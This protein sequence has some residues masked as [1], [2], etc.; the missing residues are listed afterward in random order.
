MTGGARVTAAN[1]LALEQ[2]P[3]FRGPMMSMNSVASSLGS[4]IGAALGGLVLVLMDW[5]VLGIVFG[6]MTLL[7]AMMYYMLTNDKQ[8]VT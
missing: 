1:S 8:I 3:G 4:A 5:A 7:A 6:A 2:V